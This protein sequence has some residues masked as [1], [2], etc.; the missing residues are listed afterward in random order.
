[1]QSILEP[2]SG[3]GTTGLVAAELGLKCD[4]HDIN[5]FLVWLTSVKC[6]N[7]NRKQVSEA[8]KLGSA[9]VSHAKQRLTKNKTFWTPPI[10]SIE[11][12]WHP[13]RLEVLAN[14]FD[15]LNCLVPKQGPERDLLLVAFCRL[16]M[17]WSNAAFNHQS[18]SFKKPETNL[19]LFSEDEEILQS[20]LRHLQSVLVAAKEP[21][22][23]IAQV[24][25]QDSREIESPNH[26]KY[27]A[28]ITSPPYPNRM[29]YIRELRP[30]MYWLGYLSRASDAG[31]LDWNAI[32]GTWGVAT[33]KLLKWNPDNN[34]QEIPSLIPIV[35]QVERTSELLSRYI[36]KYFIDMSKHFSSLYDAVSPGGKIFYI[37]GNSKFYE[38]LVPVEHLYAELMETNGF[39]KVTV[40]T[41]RKR[42]SKKELYEFL[43][44]AHRP[45]VVK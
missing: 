32:G 5:P 22:P 24:Y 37:V 8:R 25:L 4:L 41:I 9:L 10:S 20:F 11:R 17:Q 35:E 21:V 31:L 42:N 40:R 27:D 2:F 19:P 13:S 33:S 18:L 29:S 6:A 7:Y 28:V 43:V 14:L 26:Q 36:L 45:Q 39:D 34:R 3:T 16:I 1:M 44:S 30:Y 15:S 12:W 23:G 38:T